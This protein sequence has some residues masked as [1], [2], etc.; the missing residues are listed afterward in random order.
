MPS[1]C[2]AKRYA[3]MRKA[4]ADALVTGWEPRG[5]CS[6]STDPCGRLV[7]APMGIGS[8]IGIGDR[9]PV[10]VEYPLVSHAK[11]DSDVL[12]VDRAPPA[13]HLEHGNAPLPG[14]R[15]W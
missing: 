8:P 15:C 6:D 2:A 12:R 1:V 14:R 11:G 7:L 5:D 13:G 4:F 10:D 3:D 9:C